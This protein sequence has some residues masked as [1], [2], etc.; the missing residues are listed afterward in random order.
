MCFSFQLSLSLSLSLLVTLSTQS[1][2]QL[3]IFVDTLREVH[4]QGMTV[5]EEHVPAR[6]AGYEAY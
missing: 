3:A 6:A 1:A 2:Q 4:S 5:L